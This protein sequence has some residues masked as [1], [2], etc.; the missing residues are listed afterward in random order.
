[1]PENPGDA[2]NLLFAQATCYA[3][4]QETETALEL[5]AAIKK[6]V[7]GGAQDQSLSVRSGLS[8]A[9]G[10]PCGKLNCSRPQFMPTADNVIGDVSCLR[11]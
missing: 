11:P 2:I 6:I 3:M 4:L 8:E 7:Q 5:L 1:V 10:Q 9:E